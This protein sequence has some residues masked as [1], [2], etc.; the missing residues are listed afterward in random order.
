MPKDLMCKQQGQRWHF[1]VDQF[2]SIRHLT[3]VLDARRLPITILPIRALGVRSTNFERWNTSTRLLFARRT[4]TFRLRKDRGFSTQPEPRPDRPKD[5]GS[6]QQ[7]T[8]FRQKSAVSRVVRTT[9]R[10]GTHLWA[11]GVVV[12][13]LLGN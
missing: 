2:V 8:T 10:P 12:L 11:A 5:Q 9:K 4:A 7:R 3:R 6:S 13:Y 1:G